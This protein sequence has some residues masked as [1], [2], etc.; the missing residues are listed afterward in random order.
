MN[1]Y[2]WSQEEYDI[3]DIYDM[4]S[5]YNNYFFEGEL[6][7][8]FVGWS[9]RMTSCAGL[10]ENKGDGCCEI[11]LSSPLLKY[12]TGNE[13]KETLLHEMIH[14]YLFV[15][16]PQA[17]MSEGGHG[18][19]FREMMHNINQITKLEITVYHNFRD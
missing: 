1:K 17:C 4:F 3:L 15:T 9:E 6:E 19:E 13:L 16:D 18:K 8:C 11:K 2:F 12:R 7:K 5:F 14:A 10:C